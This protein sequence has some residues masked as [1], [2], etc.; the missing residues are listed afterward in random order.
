MRLQTRP[1]GFVPGAVAQPVRLWHA[2]ADQEVP[3]PAAE[4]TA[5][6]FPAARLTEQRAPDHIPSEATVGELFA[7]LRAVSL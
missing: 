4:A 5:A 6:L 1:W 7:E 2:P 3:F